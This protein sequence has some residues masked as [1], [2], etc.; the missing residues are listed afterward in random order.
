MSSGA[1]FLIAVILHS[2]GWELTQILL[3]AFLVWRPKS[4]T[5]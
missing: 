2:A 5:V 1:M 4:S 3:L